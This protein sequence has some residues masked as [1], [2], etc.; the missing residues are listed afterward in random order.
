MAGLLELR[1]QDV[2]RAALDKRGGAQ[3]STALHVAAAYGKAEAIR[4]LSAGHCPKSAER[5]Q[6]ERTS[7]GSVLGPRRG[8]TGFVRR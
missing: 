2:G 3:G 7:M 6:G 1:L 5:L 8:G 4:L